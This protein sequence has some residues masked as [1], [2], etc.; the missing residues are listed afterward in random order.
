MASKKIVNAAN[1]ETLGAKRLATLLMEAADRDAGMKRR[2]RLELAAAKAPESLAAEVRKRLSQISRTRSYADWHH[3]RE[4]ADDLNSQRQTIVDQVAKIDATDA[5][6]LMWRFMELAESVY[7]RCDDSNGLIGDVFRAA[8]RDL[9]PLAHMA[10]SD[11]VALADRIF[12]ALND[13]GYGQYDCLIATLAPVLGKTGL[14]HLKARFIELSKIP[15]EK[16]PEGKRKAIGWGTGG[17]VYEDEIKARSR[18]TTIRVALR[19]IADAQGDVDAFIAQYD[20]QT[21]KVPKIAAE[22]AR[23]LVAA[24]RKEEALQTI[25]AAQHR[26]SE[27]PDFD[28]EDARIQA[29]DALGRGDDAQAARWSCFER[30]LSEGHLR[31]HLKRLPDFDDVDAE[32]RALDHAEHY[33][34]LL[35]ALAFLVFWP[36]LDRAA[37][38]VIGRAAEL[39]GD[40]YEILSP[41]ADANAP[42]VGTHRVAHFPV[43][44]FVLCRDMRPRPN[45]LLFQRFLLG[46]R[47]PR[48][49]GES[50]RRN[51]RQTKNVTPIHCVPPGLVV[52]ARRERLRIRYVSLVNDARRRHHRCPLSERR[53]RHP[54]P[55]C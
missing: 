33:K 25:E 2:L 29:L 19:E 37:R 8:C 46:D 22:I 34:S 47:I 6:D 3:A 13:N 12:T 55:G 45:K 17:P 11:P 5:L 1:L 26:R 53:L 28:W 14:D 54:F 38:L 36:A 21:R 23:R 41:A 27:W 31:A 30:A 39:D 50:K 44:K 15:I 42:R 51:G 9:G 24:G 20:E 4:L 32:R 18:E 43:W 48:H 35:Q 7:E 10:K 16:P 52:H 49:Q 40:H